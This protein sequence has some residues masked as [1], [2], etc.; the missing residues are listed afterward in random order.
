MAYWF[1]R[2]QSADCR[3]VTELLQVTDPQRIELDNQQQSV[4]LAAG[5]SIDLGAVAK[6]YFA[7]QL[8]DFLS[9]LVSVPL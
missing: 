5:M 6:G 4:A 3:K 2:C 7:D 8:A 1:L 9:N